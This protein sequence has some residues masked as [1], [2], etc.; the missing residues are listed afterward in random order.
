MNVGEKALA[1]AQ[2]KADSLS[3]AFP[4]KEMVKRALAPIQG[5]CHYC[6]MLRKLDDWVYMPENGQRSAYCWYCLHKSEHAQ[7][8]GVKACIDNSEAFI[9]ECISQI[10]P[11]YWVMLQPP[12]WSVSDVKVHAKTQMLREAVRR[13]TPCI[14][15]F[16]RRWH[17]NEVDYIDSCK[18]CCKVSGRVYCTR[19]GFLCWKCMY[20]SAY[21]YETHRTQVDVKLKQRLVCEGARFLAV[22]AG[23]DD[24]VPCLQG[25]WGLQWI[26]WGRNAIETTDETLSW[27]MCPDLEADQARLD[28]LR[29]AREKEQEVKSQKRLGKLRGA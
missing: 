3:I 26:E 23:L 20:A 19:I 21:D 22:M 27:P 17:Y 10:V 12:R 16:S 28:R 14:G 9:R 5:V 25:T 11:D 7:N 24:K 15:R 18:P 29:L 2:A 6:K 13:Y 1:K 4:D 8:I